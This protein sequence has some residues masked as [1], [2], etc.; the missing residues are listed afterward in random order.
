[1]ESIQRYRLG[2]ELNERVGL[3][4][5]RVGFT[6]E[7]CITAIPH[8]YL[9]LDANRFR[10]VNLHILDARC[11]MMSGDCQSVLLRLVSATHDS[12]WASES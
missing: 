5:G 12:S 6:V 8:S 10:L 1:M 11:T 9:K 2:E 7:R 4:H 3:G